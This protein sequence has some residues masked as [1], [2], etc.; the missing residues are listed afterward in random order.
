MIQDTYATLLNKKLILPAQSPAYLE[1][2]RDFFARVL[3]D[4]IA[5]IFVDEVWYLDNYPDVREGVENGDF[6]DAADHYR[7]V[8]YI[9]HRMPHEVHVDEPWY[10]EHYPDVAVAVQ[11]GFFSSGRAHYYQLGY[12]EGRTPY[13]NFGLRECSAAF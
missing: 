10:L 8:G 3:A 1:V 9:E 2:E 7:T 6:K 13:A 5:G 4:S 11:K 12:R